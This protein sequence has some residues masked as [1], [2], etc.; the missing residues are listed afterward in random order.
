MTSALNNSHPLDRGQADGA[1]I[2]EIVGECTRDP[3]RW[4]AEAS[5]AEGAEAAKAVCR[6]CARRWLCAREA[7]ETPGSEGIWAGILVPEAGRGRT[8]ALKQLTSL[9]ERGGYPVRKRARRP[10][11]EVE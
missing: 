5:F 11:S 3:D 7:V 6:G 4:M 1:P 2:H 8:F 10:R 9:A